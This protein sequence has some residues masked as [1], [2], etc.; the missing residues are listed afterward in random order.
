[1]GRTKMKRFEEAQTFKGY[2]ISREQLDEH[3]NGTP[4][5]IVANLVGAVLISAVFWHQTPW[6]MLLLWYVVFIYASISRYSLLKKSVCRDLS[7]AQMRN[8]KK[9]IAFNAATYAHVWGAGVACLLTIATPVQ[10]LLLAV[11]GA[12]KMS[13]GVIAY[14]YIPEATKAWVTIFC[15]TLTVGLLNHGGLESYIAIGLLVVFSVTLFSHSIKIYAGFSGQIDARQEIIKSK[16]TVR[17]L[18]NDFEEQSSS[19]LF[20]TDR[21]GQLIDVCERFSDAANLPATKM[22]G[23][24]LDTFLAEDG[25][26]RQLLNHFK[27]NHSFRDLTVIVNTPDGE[28]WWNI[29]ARPTTDEENPNIAF[30]G[31]MEDITA[32]KNAEAKISYMAHFDGL[33]DL[34]NRRFFNDQLEQTVE[35][36][37]AED[38]IALLFFD[39]DHFKVINDTLGHP[40]GD[41]LLQQIASRLKEILEPEDLLARVGGDEFALLLMGQRAR[42]AGSVANKIVE[43]MALPFVIDGRNADTGVSVGLV[44]WNP[45]IRDASKLLKFADLA[46]YS[47]KGAGRNQVAIFEQGMDVAAEARRSLERDL[48]AA[49]GRDEMRLH[50]QPLINI[51]TQQRIGFEALLRWEHPRRGTV[52]PDEFIGVAEETGMIVPLG[53]WVIRKALEDAASWDDGLTVAVNLSPAQMR[54]PA[55]VATIINALAKSGL[56]PSRLELEITESI[57]L[58]DSD[59]NI[60]TLHK[61]RDLGIRISLDD[62]G[63][64]YSSL[65]YLR[66]F[67]FDKIKIDRCFVSEVD[68]REDCRA[69]IRSV[70]NLAQTLGMK[71]TAE[72]V[73]RED[74]MNTLRQEG[75]DQVQGF[76]YGRA[77]AIVPSGNRI[78]PDNV[79]R[80][81]RLVALQEL[82]RVQAMKRHQRQA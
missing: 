62:F 52:M 63:T 47:A 57:L 4:A 40:S 64:G 43:Q 9:K 58:Q 26:S 37:T 10:L 45:E 73:E 17:L 55:L 80:N 11:V 56:D 81:E 12:G 39:L 14:R 30:R 71:T 5:A 28:R 31:V 3:A 35:R 23:V 38:E 42:H 15:S 70:I 27:A 22:N 82:A 66:S 50:Y 72:G 53:E 49:L 51:A 18:L 46:L 36:A 13:V 16:E 33:T 65:N 77:E 59:A 1:M 2:I 68:S 34:P 25:Q 60:R 67:P 32:Q 48:R 8:I 78:L 20:A 76:L 61:L 41:K 19:W 79:V 75:C 6:A 54:S 44:Q 21:N 7:F 29:S 69:I 24:A 74:Q